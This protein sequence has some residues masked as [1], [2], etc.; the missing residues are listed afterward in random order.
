MP[1][2]PAL[3]LKAPPGACDSHIHF[4]GPTT[5]YPFAGDAAYHSPDALPET[6]FALQNALGLERAIVIHPTALGAR[7]NT[8]TLDALA[9]WPDRLRGVAVLDRTVD[10]D[11]LD[12]MHALGVRGCRFNSVSAYANA[13]GLDLR[14]VERIAERGWHAQFLIGGEQI[15]AM[16]DTITSLPCPAVI[17]HM[18]RVPAHLGVDCDAFRTLLEM[19]ETGQVWVKVSGP[20][21]FSNEPG[22]PY[23]D[24]LPFARALVAANPERLV[25]GSDWPH[26]NYNHG[27]MPDDGSL[28]DMMLDWVPDEAVRNRILA[29]NPAELYGFP[30]PE[31]ADVLNGPTPDGDRSRYPA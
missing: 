22:M 21:R 2:T 8:R 25:W 18:G 19:L 6:Y 28:L 12:R 17:D 24:T 13:P 30:R 10:D 1:K 27:T 3:N 26:I 29:D 20:M 4:F 16:R 5:R 15:P 7:G 11:T 23:A 14:L 9:G 31:Q